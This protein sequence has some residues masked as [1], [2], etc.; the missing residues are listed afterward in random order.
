MTI[1]S[2]RRAVS[3][4]VV[5]VAAGMALTACGPGDGEASSSATKSSQVGVA[6]SDAD[7][8]SANGDRR[9]GNDSSAAD[10][11]ARSDSEADA[12][13]RRGEEADAGSRRGE[14][15][16][17]RC[18]SDDLK[19]SM[20]NQ[21]GG[22]GSIRFQV[23]FKNTSSSPCS[24]T[25]F[26]GV[27]F[28]GRDGV[29]IGKAASR[30]SSVEATKVTLIPNGHAVME[31]KARNGQSGLSEEECQPKSVAFL[32]V[33]APGSKDHFNLPRKTTACSSR[34]ANGLSVGAVHSVR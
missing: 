19:I 1:T 31:V 23:V 33:Y 27:S 15:S 6:G 18:E 2:S 7:S 28:R 13:S 5:V 30:D 14:D 4:F 8:R 20:E 34:S 22:A 26:P 9:G 12:G 3:A 17:A 16:D 32:R 10:D 24:L 25:G 21:E 29:Q 11:S